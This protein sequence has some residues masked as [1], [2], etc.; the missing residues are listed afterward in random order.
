MWP[1]RKLKSFLQNWPNLKTA[2]VFL[3]DIL[4]E[5]IA[6]ILLLYFTY[7]FDQIVFLCKIM[8]SMFSLN[9]K[10][11]CD[12]KGKYE[13]FGD[14]VNMKFHDIVGFI[15]FLIAITIVIVV[16]TIYSSPKQ[17]AQ[18]FHLN[19]SLGTF[20][21]VKNGKLEVSNLSN[22]YVLPDFTKYKYAFYDVE[23]GEFFCVASCPDS[24]DYSAASEGKCSER[25]DTDISY[26]RLSQPPCAYSTIKIGGL[27]TPPR[28][29]I[30][31]YDYFS[32]L[33]FFGYI[34]AACNLYKVEVTLFSLLSV[35][36]SCVACLLMSRFTKAYIYV[37]LG[38][39]PF[40]VVGA[41][42]GLYVLSEN[43]EADGDNEPAIVCK[44][45][46]I[47]MCCIGVVLILIIIFLSK[48]VNQA[49]E[50][51]EL[52]LSSFT[53]NLY[54]MT[55]P[56]IALVFLVLIYAILILTVSYSDVSNNV[57]EFNGMAIV[58]RYLGG[59]SADVYVYGVIMFILLT[60]FVL[61]AS[62]AS[63]SAS[64]VNWYFNKDKV[65]MGNVF[66]HSTFVIPCLKQCG[67]IMIV[68]ILS[69]ALF[70]VIKLI[71]AYI[72][73]MN[74]SGSCIV[75]F[76]TTCL[77]CCLSCLLSLYRYSSKITLTFQQ[78]MNINWYQATFK[79]V[80]ILAKE[81]VFVTLLNGVSR[82]SLGVTKI[83]VAF[84]CTAPAAIYVA[85]VSLDGTSILI[86][87]MVVLFAS[88]AFATLFFEMLSNI[89][90]S[91]FGCLLFERYND[92]AKTVENDDIKGRVQ[93]LED[94]R[95]Q[96]DA[97]HSYAPLK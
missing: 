30:A 79:S 46:A 60:Y 7:N 38:T 61:Y 73:R 97:S 75:K 67:S 42:I 43:L 48:K 19:D 5:L 69:T 53:H 35:V 11:E 59:V 33:G 39:V 70:I 88:Y 23:R 83:L 57:L 91:V 37:T 29:V 36:L 13:S 68:S 15:T 34:A 81:I 55:Y 31:L 54:I 41:G 65:S 49:I 72:R 84:L 16:F 2:E 82:F 71:Q 63:A 76:C 14:I 90:D 17:T 18:L 4:P 21:G 64:V 62:Y 95:D 9:D 47:I 22:T 87:S 26:Y 58:S 52:A 32:G 8:T 24:G 94:I 93:R 92:S 80:E 44:V 85:N 40:I 6:F 56:F 66:V 86:V 3:L 12:F 10:E 77:S 51:I 78:I 27:C 1:Q 89:I 25:V 74:R 45:A 96:I 28:D 20:C 50:V